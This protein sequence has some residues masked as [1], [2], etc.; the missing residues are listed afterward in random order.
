VGKGKDMGNRNDGKG[1][2]DEGGKGRGIGKRRGVLQ[3]LAT[4]QVPARGKVGSEQ[5]GRT[6][7]CCI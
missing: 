7:D 3:E 6:Y 1:G 4:G 5:Y 2:T